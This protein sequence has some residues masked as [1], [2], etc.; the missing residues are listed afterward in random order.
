MSAICAAERFPF[1][2]PWCLL[3]VKPLDAVELA[4]QISPDPIT[5]DDV[6]L[7]YRCFTLR[8]AASNWSLPWKRA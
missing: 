5:F 6:S 3:I 4:V 1:P 2:P 8:A 7:R